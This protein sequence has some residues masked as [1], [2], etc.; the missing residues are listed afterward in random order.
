[1]KQLQ[2]L[3]RSYDSFQRKHTFFGFFYAVIKRYSEDQVGNQA[4]L[5]TY[6]GFLALF[7]LL[8]V[9]TTLLDIFAGSH[10]HV[11]QTVITSLTNYFPVLGSQLSSHIHGLH[12]SGLALVVGLILTLYGSRGVATV[13]QRGVNQIWQTEPKQTGNFYESLKRSFTL[14]FIGGLGFMA[15]SLLAGYAGAVGHGLEFRALSLAINVFIL[16]WLFSILLNI[17]LPRHV[18]LRETYVGAAVAA[19]GLV[20]LQSVGSFL[21]ARDLKK[22]DA[23]YSTFAISLGLLFWIYLQVRVFYYAVVIATVHSQKLWPR[24][25]DA[26]HPSDADRRAL[27]KRPAETSL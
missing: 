16:F 3:I 24:S 4:A 18:S 13:F 14:I 11:Q 1:M 5:L 9:L 2:K 22:L 20:V 15:A 7:P 12:K 26:A 17:S 21:L 10:S 25:L 23:L 27:L 19:L 6:Y 8:L